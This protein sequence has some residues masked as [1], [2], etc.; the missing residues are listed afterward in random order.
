LERI[1]ENREKKLKMFVTFPAA[2]NCW[3][4]CFIYEAKIDKLFN[5]YF[6]KWKCNIVKKNIQFGIEGYFSE[7]AS[8]NLARLLFLQL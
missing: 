6:S 8:F 3:I 1:Q 7:S 4:G 5:Q 2:F